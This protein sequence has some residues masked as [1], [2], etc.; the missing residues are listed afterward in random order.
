MR[1]FVLTSLRLVCNIYARERAMGIQ[2]GMGEMIGPTVGIR[3]VFFFIFLLRMVHDIYLS[4]NARPSYPPA[5]PEQP[6]PQF[7]MEM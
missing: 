5:T 4:S 7:F 1:Y 3:L 2:N 6:P